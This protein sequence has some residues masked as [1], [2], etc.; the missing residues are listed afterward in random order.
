M[1]NFTNSNHLARSEH[2]PWGRPQEQ[3]A[4]TIKTP[5]STEL[6]D[7]AEAFQEV[8]SSV[9]SFYG[10]K[11]TGLFAAKPNRPVTVS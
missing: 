11:I 3:F 7:T 2:R 10:G 8:F 6:P 1:L 9:W 5:T 4:R